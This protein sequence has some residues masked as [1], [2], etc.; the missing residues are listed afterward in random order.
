MGA[1]TVSR[2]RTHWPIRKRTAR[3]RGAVRRLRLSWRESGGPAVELPERRGFGAGLIQHGLAR[4]LNGEVR[5]DYDPGGVVC[6]VDVPILADDEMLRRTL[7]SEAAELVH[8]NAD[9]LRNVGL[10]K[11]ATL[12]RGE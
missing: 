7:L 2:R 10:E 4:E 11:T 8:R 1:F 5:V 3:I 9:P 6:T 12:A